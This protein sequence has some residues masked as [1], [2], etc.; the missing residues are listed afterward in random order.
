MNRPG[1]D[2]T[3]MDIYLTGDDPSDPDEKRILG[4]KIESMNKRLG[5]RVVWRRRMTR[6]D[7]SRVWQSSVGTYYL[8]GPKP[9]T[10]YFMQ[11]N[12]PW[13]VENFDY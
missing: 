3:F 7:L 11:Y 12:L 9:F 13:L 5:N 8:C 10:K 2:T 4:K 1:F 6:Q